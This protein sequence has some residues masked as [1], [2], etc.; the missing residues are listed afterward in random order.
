MAVQGRPVTFHEM[1]RADAGGTDHGGAGIGCAREL[2]PAGV[3]GAAGGDVRRWLMRL[4][5]RL[6]LW[7]VVWMR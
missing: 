3:D 5:R 7:R 4:L 2:L 1:R 6:R